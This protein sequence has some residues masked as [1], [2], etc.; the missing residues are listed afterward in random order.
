MES[1]GIYRNL[2]DWVGSFFI[3]FNRYSC[4]L[5]KL[6]FLIRNAS[7]FHRFSCFLNFYRALLYYGEYSRSSSDFYQRFWQPSVICVQWKLD[8]EY[9][10]LMIQVHW[11]DIE[12]I[13]SSQTGWNLIR[14]EWLQNFRIFHIMIIK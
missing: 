9:F 8:F 13:S 4:A 11:L 3:I 7:Y 2:I 14:F 10:R 5:P 6:N 12:S 1:E